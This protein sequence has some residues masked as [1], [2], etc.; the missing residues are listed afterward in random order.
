MTPRS[1]KPSSHFKEVKELRAM[2]ASLGVSGYWV[3]TNII[4]SGLKCGMG[5]NDKVAD[6]IE[7]YAMYCDIIGFNYENNLGCYNQRQNKSENFVWS[8]TGN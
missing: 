7:F 6:Q 4:D 5:P 1:N 8:E 2:M 3:I